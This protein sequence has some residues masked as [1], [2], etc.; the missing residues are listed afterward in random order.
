VGG[1]VGRKGATHADRLVVGVGVYR[2]K[3]QS[4]AAIHAQIVRAQ[5]G[6]GRLP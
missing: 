3:N 6:V 1:G 4:A 5:G 2:H